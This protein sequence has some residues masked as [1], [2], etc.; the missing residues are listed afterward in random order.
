MTEKL[1]VAMIDDQSLC[2]SGLSELLSHCYDMDV[3][4]AVGS[5]EELRLLIKKKPDLLIVDLRMQPMDGKRSINPN[6][7]S[8]PYRWLNPAHANSTATAL[9]SLPL[10]ERRA[11]HA[12]HGAARY[13]AHA[14][15]LWPSAAAS[16][17]PR[18]R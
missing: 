12:T 15:W 3:L 5:L 11:S 14:R 2:R 1:K 6:L 4:G 17:S 13:R 16:R 18:W 10:F 7:F 9:R 8:S